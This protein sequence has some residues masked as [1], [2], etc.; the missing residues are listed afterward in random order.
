MKKL[1]KIRKIFLK[2]NGKTHP[3]PI[4][5]DYLL[6]HNPDLPKRL[7]NQIAEGLEP[8]SFLKGRC[9]L[10]HETE[11]NRE[12][13]NDRGQ[14]TLRFG[15]NIKKV[16]NPARLFYALQYGKVGPCLLRHDC[17]D[18]SGLCVN[19]SHLTQGT[20]SDN[21]R[22]SKYFKAVQ[23][24]SGGQNIADIFLSEPFRLW[25]GWGLTQLE[26]IYEIWNGRKSPTVIQGAEEAMLDPD[27]EFRGD[28]HDK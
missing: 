12:N 13:V 1:A 14:I 10:W 15:K 16:M 6:L 9:W 24:A 4:S 23:E 18:D 17:G 28:G 8:D 22:D 5:R 11:R 21:K 20:V 2:T 7:L 3:I 25:Q 19:P 26:E 27:F